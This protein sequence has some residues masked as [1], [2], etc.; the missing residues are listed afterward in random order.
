MFPGLDPFLTGCGIILL[1]LLP[2]TWISRP[3]PEDRSSFDWAWIQARRWAGLFSKYFGIPFGVLLII[4]GIAE[5]I[6]SLVT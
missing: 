6:V 5:L 3:V 1:S 2:M 4:A